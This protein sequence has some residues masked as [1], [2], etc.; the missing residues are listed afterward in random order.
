MA[1]SKKTTKKPTR[2]ERMAVA[3][4]AR[5][6]ALTAR[7]SGPVR[8]QLLDGAPAGGGFRDTLD[9]RVFRV[10]ES[11]PRAVVRVGKRSEDVEVIA[12]TPFVVA[13]VAVLAERWLVAGG[14]DGTHVFDL[15]DLA[16]GPVDVLPGTGG[17]VHPEPALGAI[18][19]GRMLWLRP[20]TQ[21]ST[22][23]YAPT[24]SK[25]RRVATLDLPLA[26]LE[27]RGE[28]LGHALFAWVRLEG[29]DAVT[30]AP[31]TAT[32]TATKPKATKKRGLELQ[33]APAEPPSPRVFD[34]ALRRRLGRDA[35]WCR[36]TD[37][38]RAVIF[39][40]KKTGDVAWLDRDGAPHTMTAPELPRTLDL[41]GDGV[42][43]VALRRRLLF[44]DEK[45]KGSPK[46]VP[47]PAKLGDVLAASFCEGGRVA[48]LTTKG[49]H[50]ATRAGAVK[51][52]VAITQPAFMVTVGG[53]AWLAV[54]SHAKTGLLVFDVTGAKL[55][56]RLRAP[57]AVVDVRAAGSRL[58]AR[59]STGAWFEV[60][61]L[62]PIDP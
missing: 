23:F 24:E 44:L 33:P 43:L 6:E 25:L 52:S 48:L 12:R 47:V 1:A 56:A 36:I 13:D 46:E 16:R 41:S 7:A 42:V 39:D 59:A 57:L 45:G 26:L 4:I 14:R 15:Q 51:A 21:R 22:S 32:A 37:D 3:E 35:T 30:A 27:R 62:A 28:V 53:G 8:V 29:L 2:G 18:L 34:A 17:R 40:G 10:V 60:T 20:S 19:G 5:I 61:G 9:R 31:E 58:F 38:G 49:L 50:L 54:T 55:V 11:E